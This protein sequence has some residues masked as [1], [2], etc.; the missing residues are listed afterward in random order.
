MA[1]ALL[2]GC[3]GGSSA[4]TGAGAANASAVVSSSSSSQLSTDAVTNSDGVT[5]ITSAV[6]P[7]GK[8]TDEENTTGAKPIKPCRLVSKA[9]AEGI[10]GTHVTV[11]ERLQ[12]PTCVYAGSGRQVTLVVERASIKALREGARKATPVTVAGRPGWCVRYES[13]SVIVSAGGG[14]VLQ[15][16]GPCAAGVRFAS[17]ALPQITG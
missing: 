4:A 15:V 3:G 7:T 13:T 1:L 9:K 10:L 14:R 6:Y 12:G 5:E 16:N 2:A 11:T 8:D 17:V